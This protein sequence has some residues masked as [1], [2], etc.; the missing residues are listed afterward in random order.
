MPEPESESPDSVESES[1]G[2][3]AAP[4]ESAG[5]AESAPAPESA[6]AV[7]SVPAPESAVAVPVPAVPA[8]P[9]WQVQ[10]KKA[11]TTEFAPHGAEV[12][13]ADARRMFED[14]LS[15]AE[16][17]DRVRL[18]SPSGEVVVNQIK[19]DA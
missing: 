5:P 14:R 17:G 8:V 16:Q 7:E 18:V 10:V 13:E 4:A 9:K 11:K 6:V 2:L 3:A 12:E 15:I 19:S 1:T